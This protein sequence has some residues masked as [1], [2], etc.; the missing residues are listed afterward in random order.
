[1]G[2]QN[3]H[4][5]EILLV[6]LS[7]MIDDC[8]DTA[9]LL[10]QRMP[11]LALVSP[12]DRRSQLRRDLHYVRKRYQSEGLGFLTKSLPLLGKWIDGFL[13]SGSLSVPPEGFAPFV[14]DFGHYPRFLQTLWRP[15]LINVQW[16]IERGEADDLT[17]RL[18]RQV[19]TICY[20]F[21]KLEVP[22]DQHQMEEA[23]R[24]FYLNDATCGIPKGRDATYAQLLV[25]QARG[26]VGDILRGFN[27]VDISPK[28]GPGSVSTGE[29]YGEKWQFSHFYPKLHQAYPYYEYMWGVR[30]GLN[31]EQLRASRDAYRGMV[32]DDRPTS[33]VVFVP[34]DSRGPRTICAE[35]LELQYI[36]QGLGRKL[37][38]HLERRYPTKGQVN[39]KDQTVNGL[40]A[41]QSSATKENATIDLKDASDLVSLELVKAIMPERVFRYLDATRSTHAY[42]PSLGV[43]VELEKYAPMG[44]A[45]CFPVESL[46]FYSLC[47]A[48]LHLHGASLNSAYRKVFVYGD[49]IIIPTDSTDL[50]IGALEAVGLKVNRG[51]CCFQSHFRESC[52]VDAWLGHSVTPQRIKKMPGRQ[53]SEGNALAAWLAYAGQF[54]TMGFH[55]AG[56]CCKQVVEDVLGFV[57]ITERAEGYLSV[58][59]PLLA[60]G[61]SCYPRTRWNAKLQTL[62][63]K[64]PCLVTKR[65]ADPMEPWNRL[66]RD[67]LVGVEGLNPEEVVVRDAT[68]T[69][70]RW[71]SI[72]CFSRS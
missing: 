9:L 71:I 54:W 50:V 13:N 3:S 12:R 45:L 34:K 23:A 41:L 57:P 43:T 36:Q 15:L 38:R 22:I 14:D 70:L 8:F 24:R 67:L 19:R 53:P 65:K 35:P 61:A 40:L 7:K 47:V 55:R 4:G 68:V 46:I 49:D 25:E 60:M 10:E 37:M 44:S 26:C 2:D 58:V 21:Y 11:Y 69:R 20:S 66:N 18:V 28:H 5:E 29:R 64:L 52:G 31:A 39:F 42:I 27:P 16:C 30:E 59:N 6:V 56:E 63:A 72:P 32:R 62:Q 51:K 1:M 33:K 17:V 48:A